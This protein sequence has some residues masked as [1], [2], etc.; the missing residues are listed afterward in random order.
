MNRI[1]LVVCSTVVAAVAGA[2]G[3]NAG[4]SAPGLTVRSTLDGKTVLPHRIHWS[5]RPSTPSLDIRKVEFFIDG[6][7]ARWVDD[8]APYTYADDGGY[9]VTSFLATGRHRFR[10]RA[11]AVD[12][13]KATD[14][15]TA[16]VLPAQ[17]PPAA[18]TGTWQRTFD[19]QGAP[20]PGSVGNPTD[21]YTPSGRYTLMFEKR[22]I[23]DDFPGAF[24]LPRSNETGE[25]LVFLSDYTATTGRLHVQ[26]EVVFHPLSM[27]DAEGGAWCYFW[28]PSADYR[29]NVSGDTLTLQPVGGNGRD[30][31][32]IRGFIWTG[33]WTRKP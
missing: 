32:R 22:W 3:V 9:L 19:T 23:R 15:V 31:C 4:S 18:L 13:R 20:A 24:V 16:R 14:T 1:L 33:A 11:T 30:A 7:K 25:G 28:G 8:H 27:S 6:G 21:T 29:W 5:A 17:E 2:T 10:V 12:G 26:G